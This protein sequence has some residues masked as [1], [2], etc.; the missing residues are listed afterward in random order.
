MKS[1]D[2]DVLDW[3][4]VGALQASLAAF[5]DSSQRIID[6]VSWSVSVSGDGCV[7]CTYH[8]RSSAVHRLTLEWCILTEAFA[9]FTIQ[10]GATCDVPR[11]SR[12]MCTNGAQAYRLPSSHAD[13]LEVPGGVKTGM[14][15]TPDGAHMVTTACKSTPTKG[16]LFAVY[17]W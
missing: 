12:D 8:V 4:E 1:D 14:A 3:V 17:R 7:S 13:T 10:V 2:P 6:G 11:S 16:C 5:D 9:A 15:L